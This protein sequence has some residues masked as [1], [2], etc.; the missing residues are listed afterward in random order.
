MKNQITENQKLQKGIFKQGDLENTKDMLLR[1]CKFYKDKPLLAELDQNKNVVKYNANQIL[2]NVCA[3]GDALLNLGLGDKHIAI[4]AKN[5]I[6]YIFCELAVTNGVGIFVPI[7]K[8]AH[9]EH[10]YNL[11]TKCKAD[12]LICDSTVYE[13]LKDILP[14][15]EKLK[16]I[17]TIDKKI[18]GFDF[19][20][21]LIERGKNLQEKKLQK[22]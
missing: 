3:L 2:E 14:K 18:E 17:I 10:A 4:M 20:D 16:K 1:M 11:L 19:V 6:Y 15:C 5:S 22:Q 12:A 7:D 13:R 21:D 9:A 8:D